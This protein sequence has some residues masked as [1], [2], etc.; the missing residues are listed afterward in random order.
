[1]DFEFGHT[2]ASLNFVKRNEA[3]LP[4]FERLMKLG[5]RCLA[6]QP[7]PKSEAEEVCFGLGHECRVDFLEVVFLAANGYSNGALKMLRGLYE[8]TVTCAFI[9][10]HPEK[11]R[12]FMDFAFIQEHRL[13]EGF[14]KLVTVEELNAQTK[15]GYTVEEIRERYKIHKEKF[16][17]PLCKNCKTTRTSI[18]W[19][20]KDPASMAHE[21]G[22]IYKR[23]Y[24]VCYSAANL[25]VHASL[26]SAARWRNR[27]NSEDEADYYV[28]NASWLLNLALRAQNKLFDLDLGSDLEA[29]WNELMELPDRYRGTASEDHGESI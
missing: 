7:K 10:E 25:S 23:L 28:I 15:R 4:K 24:S 2:Q 27:G 18:S 11:A 26:A 22:D 1:M 17:V 5:N 12:S 13:M 3:F 14:L 29:S 6:R 9:V 16:Q 19:D 21:L 8:R 20:E